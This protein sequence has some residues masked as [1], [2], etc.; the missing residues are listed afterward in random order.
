MNG[1]GKCEVY[2]AV[3][4]MVSRYCND[5]WMGLE[6]AFFVGDSGIPAK[7]AKEVVNLILREREAK[8]PAPKIMS[9]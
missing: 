4:K 8:N 7:L 9:V 2:H 5:S 3:E 1:E 6:K